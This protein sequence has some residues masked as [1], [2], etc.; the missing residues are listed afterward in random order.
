M[1]LGH[2]AAT[3]RLRLKA[4]KVGRINIP[5]LIQGE[6]G[7][8]KEVLARSI[9]RLSPWRDGPFVSVNCPAI[10]SSLLESELFGYEKG[11]FTGAH[12]AKPGWVE[13]ASEGTLFLD[14]VAELDLALQPK[15]LRF[16]QDGT[17]FQIGGREEKRAQVRVI[18]A[19]NRELEDEVRAGRF[20]SDL[21]YRINVIGLRMPPLRERRS[22]IPDLVEYFLRLYNTTYR[23]Q[24]SPLSGRMLQRLLMHD[25]RGNVRELENVMRRYV[26]MNSEEAIVNELRIAPG[27]VSP[28]AEGC[29]RVSLRAQTEAAV[30]PFERERVLRVLEANEWNRRK[31]AR[32]LDISYRALFYKMRKLGVASQPA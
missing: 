5:V 8:G 26:V 30:R 12:A 29:G 18:C 6:S 16:L 3:Q 4:E 31:A 20:R 9:H 7:T 28:R 1:L 13:L 11:S 10:P 2:S 22:D 32:A 15:L 23:R 21:F 27:A 17:F 25:W 24:A 19:T 14:E